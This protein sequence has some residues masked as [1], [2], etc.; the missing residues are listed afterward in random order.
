MLPAVSYIPYAKSPKEKAGDI[1]T[2]AQFE[3]EGLLSETRNDTG[4]GNKYDDDSTLA[5]LIS[6]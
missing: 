2:F 3:E 6:E 5:T 1:I 4:S